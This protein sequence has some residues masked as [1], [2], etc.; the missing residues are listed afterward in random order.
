M[1]SLSPAATSRPR[2]DAT[3]TCTDEDIRS[4]FLRS[5]HV[6]GDRAVRQPFVA[7]HQ[8]RR[9][10]LVLWWLQWPSAELC[11]PWEQCPGLL[12]VLLGEHSIDKANCSNVMSKLYLGSASNIHPLLDSPLAM[13]L[14][15]KCPN[16]S[17]LLSS[18]VSR[19]SSRWGHDCCIRYSKVR[20]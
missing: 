6:G 19:K 11:R 7:G 16:N 10:T 4:N 5:M 15:T 1:S 14:I 2:L 18:R 9:A 3:L 13:V 17:S 20:I 12:V 8:H